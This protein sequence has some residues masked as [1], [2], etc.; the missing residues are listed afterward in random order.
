MCP[1]ARW[2][3]T[4]VTADEGTT[5]CVREGKMTELPKVRFELRSGQALP[6]V[7]ILSIIR[8]VQ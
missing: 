1:I 8:F 2:C 4:L 6:F 3:I 5:C 7:Q